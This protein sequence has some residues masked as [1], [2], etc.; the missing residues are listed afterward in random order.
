[1]TVIKS[2]DTFLF[3]DRN[4]DISQIPLRRIYYPNVDTYSNILK[5]CNISKNSFFI[6]TELFDN[7]IWLFC[8]ISE[9]ALTKHVIS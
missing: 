3:I 9:I 2:I 6:F 5:C 1:M 7:V 8:S 4:I